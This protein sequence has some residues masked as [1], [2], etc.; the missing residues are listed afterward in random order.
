MKI[1]H[2]IL[3]RFGYKHI[4]N[5]KFPNGSL[6]HFLNHISELGFIPEH[7]FDVGANKGLWSTI[8]KSV[9]TNSKFTLIEPQIE[10]APYLDR[11]CLESPGSKWINA[12]AGS[13]EG[14]MLFT[15][16]SDTVSSSFSISKE[17]ASKDGYEQRIVPI[18]TLDSVC[19]DNIKAIPDVVKLDVEGF[20][21][22]VLQGS[23]TLFGETEIFLLEVVFFGAHK[24]AKKVHE[25]FSIMYDFGYVPY[26]FTSFEA[27]P[28]DGALGL[29]EVAFAKT[30]G[31]LRSHKAWR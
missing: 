10:M 5:E 24:N 20:E 26:N 19:R 30:N 3:S 6:Y 25:I 16:V 18:I 7:I 15:V 11:F 23:S 2:K 13:K 4:S 9:F 14:E 21:Y 27:R 28:F 17:Q 1:A 8:A 12:G 29:C 31:L 22:E